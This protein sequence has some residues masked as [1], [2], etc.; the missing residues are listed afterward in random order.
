MKVQKSKK[1]FWLMF[2]FKAFCIIKA[3]RDYLKLDNDEK[4]NYPSLGSKGVWLNRT[5]KVSSLKQLHDII[6]TEMVQKAKGKLFVQAK[7]FANEIKQLKREKEMIPESSTASQLD[8]F[9]DN[10][11]LLHVGERLIKSNLT[12]KENHVVIFP[13]KCTVSNM[14]IQ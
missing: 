4:G 3:A 13:K 5:E 7:S 10:R 14:V 1:W 11:G 9:L 6:D 12:E 2:T 8:P